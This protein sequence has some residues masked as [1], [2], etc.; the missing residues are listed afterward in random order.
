[1][2]SRFPHVFRPLRIAGMTIPNRVVRTAHTTHQPLSAQEPGMADYHVARAR[3]G[4]GLTILG[5]ASV[6]LSAPMEIAAHLDRVVPEYQR[7]MEALAPYDMKVMQQLWH[8]GS[9][10]HANAL[11][12]P[13][14]SASDVPNPVRGLTPTPM[15]KTMIDDVVA[16]FRAAA[17]RVKR[18]GLHGVEVHAG[19][20][21]LMSQF[22][23]PAT[24][25]RTDDYGGTPENRLRFL[26]EVLAA[27]RD[28]VGPEYPVGVRLSSDDDVPGG[29]TPTDARSIAL[30]IQPMVDFLDVSFG[31]YY[32]FNRMMAT[33]D[34][35]PLG[36]ELESSQRVTR[37]LDVPTIV[38]GR[39][40]TVEH[41]E[42]VIS[43]GIAD[44]VSM[45]RALIADPDIVAKT[46][47]GEEDRI[48]P[49]IGTNEGCVASR[50][51]NFGCVVNPEAGKEGSW[52]P[53]PAA[54]TRP[55]RV[56]VG[57]G[58]PA[59]LEAARTAALRGHDVTLLELT[60][61]LGGQ[62][63]VA[64]RAPYR[65]DFGMHVQWLEAEVRR[66]GVTVRLNTPVEPDIVGDL[67]PDVVVL[68][69][70]STPRTDGFSVQRPLQRFSS[71]QQRLLKTSWDVFGFG[72]SLGPCETVVVYDDAG[73]FEGISV[74][75]E[76][77]RRGATVTLATRQDTFGSGMPEPASTAQAARD[78]L[79]GD[80]RLTLLSNAVLADVD[81]AGVEVEFLGSGRRLR[82]TTEAVVVVG[83]NTSNSDVVEAVRESFGG[84]V[85]VVGDALE[86]GRLREA[87]TQGATIGRAL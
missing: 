2:S 47:R 72:G 42:H 71:A 55:R 73:D 3:G 13:L 54:A 30:A 4:V 19:H 56:L 12:G 33:A 58:G 51:G 80:P 5:A 44:M 61:Q 74:V 87:V 8:P 40:M 25:R 63:Q 67:A 6:H 57:G 38:T 60:G 49:C 64:A 45:V 18:G 34:G 59:G 20:N 43:S 10:G 46:L 23:S 15:T 36:Y 31:G 86:P 66:L 35:Y 14:W 68:A 11:G 52:T 79:A 53:T 21:Y 39:I 37:D 78:R 16:G 81:A 1:M 27:I 75:E 65:S 76:L 41:A 70:G 29:L 7:F 32:R 26:R 24:N 82:C 17:G 85:H 50:R 9:A 84:E 28:E 62:V 48:R 83:A 77:L 69:V 22:L